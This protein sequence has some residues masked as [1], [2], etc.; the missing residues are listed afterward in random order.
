MT[1]QK[2]K[3]IIVQ[4][5]FKNGIS[6]ALIR[7]TYFEIGLVPILFVTKTITTK[8]K[9]KWDQARPFEINFKPLQKNV[10]TKTLNQKKKKLMN[11]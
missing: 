1:K 7:F 8:N 4:I 9:N 6:I 2:P 3:V 11:S 5:T 10:Q